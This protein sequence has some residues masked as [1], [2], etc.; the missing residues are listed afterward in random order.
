MAPAGTT[1]VVVLLL[2]VDFAGGEN[3]M[4]FDFAEASLVTDEPPPP[5]PE[6]L[7]LSN[8]GFE[9]GDLTDWT[10]GGTVGAP[11]VGARTGAFAAQLTTA[12]G[13]G[14]GEIRQ[15]Y[16]AA[17]GDEVNFSAWMLTESGAAD[18]RHLWSGQ[19]RLPGRGR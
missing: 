8:G 2:N 4:W 7:A 11:G 12:G 19:D 10:G 1:Q 13:N 18:G 6:G 3:P 14:V 15:T 5:P 9:T 16:D 17:P